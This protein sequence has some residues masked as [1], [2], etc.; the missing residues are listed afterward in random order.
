[1]NK[2]STFIIFTDAQIESDRPSFRNQGLT[3]GTTT[4]N[5]YKQASQTIRFSSLLGPLQTAKYVNT[6]SYLSRGHL[7]PD[8]DF[9]LGGWSTATYF[10]VNAA[11]Q[12]QV[13]NAGNWLRV[14]S[15]A[16]KVAD[17]RQE[18]L[19]II[20]GTREVL[21]LKSDLGLMV[22]IFLFDV[23]KL[24]VPKWLWKIVCSPTTSQCIAF[25]TLNNPHATFISQSELLCPD[26]CATS[27]WF[28]PEYSEFTK[29]YTYCCEVNALLAKVGTLSPFTISVTGVLTGPY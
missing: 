15:N 12:W 29:G 22:E 6:T 17:L 2:N 7:A 11:P 21:K 25:V 20:T 26:I 16:R 14:E 18:D 28:R 8:G 24:A 23:K 3:Y 19:I 13:V 9:L 27:G 10:Y 4:A 5:Q 1:M